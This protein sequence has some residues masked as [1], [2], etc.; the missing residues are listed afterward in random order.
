MK[1][2]HILDKKTQA[3]L[4]SLQIGNMKTGRKD[5]ITHNQINFDQ[6]I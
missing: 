3:S 5:V 1:P 2:S 4:N 6:F